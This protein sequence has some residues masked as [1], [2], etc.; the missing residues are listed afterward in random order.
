MPSHD[1]SNLRKPSFKDKTSAHDIRVATID[2]R[3]ARALAR[4]L[5]LVEVE[6]SM[7]VPMRVFYKFD[8]GRWR[9][10]STRQLHRVYRCK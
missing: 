7:P 9:T 1:D 10:R 6:F 2:G 4:L 5:R 3:W 8:S